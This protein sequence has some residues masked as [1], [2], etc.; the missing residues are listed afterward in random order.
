MAR[1]AKWLDTEDFSQLYLDSA[2]TIVIY[3][4]WP[5][6]VYHMGVNGRLEKVLSTGDLE[7]AKQEAESVI[8]RWAAGL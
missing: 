7:S 2:L 6:K 3:K 4:P 5:D 1:T 8:K